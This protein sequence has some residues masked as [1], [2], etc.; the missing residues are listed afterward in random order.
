MPQFQ[1]GLKMF[2]S[3]E[4]LL[5]ILLTDV[6]EVI[7]HGR[8][9]ILVLCY[10]SAALTPLTI[11]YFPIGYSISFGMIV[12]QTGLLYGSILFV[13]IGPYEV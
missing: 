1:S 13:L 10:I 12:S 3:I 6:F 8:V 9:N 7:D 11:Q 2:L 4:T 5:V